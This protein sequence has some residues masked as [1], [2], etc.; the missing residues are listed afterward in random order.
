MTKF[1]LKLSGLAFV[2]ALLIATGCNT[3]DP[4]IDN[5]LGP[6][7]SL[8]SGDLELLEGE[9]FSVSITVAP[10]DN[11]LSSLRL[12]VGG[13]SVPA[14][15]ISD[16]VTKITSGG[17]DIL[18]QN[19]LGIDASRENG[20]TY[21]YEMVPFGQLEGETVSYSFEVTDKAQE[22]ASVSFD[23]TIVAPPGTP[24]EKEISGALLNQAGPAGTGGLD[25]DAGTGTGSNAAE[26]EIQ[27]EGID[28]NLS[29][30]NNWRRQIS[31][32][33]ANG[34]SL[35]TPDLTKLP[36]NFSFENI[37]IKEQ[38]KE[39]YDTGLALAGSDAACNCSDDVSG[40]EVSEPVEVG[41]MFVVKK[42]DVYYIIVATA[43]NV[44][45]GNNNDSYQ[46]DIKY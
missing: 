31:A 8:G 23:I 36:E 2:L 45:D 10:G 40:E 24:I 38:I 21:V 16:Y 39:A 9:A 13:A 25:L 37:T 44:T 20:A 29:T 14:A 11:P 28:L 4:I 42:G 3:D 17:E 5:P 26:A 46:F 32:V 27:D 1:F 7:I 15:S 22:K 30:A 35:R 43:V 18:Q 41:D 19:P 6:E 12:L 33:D 34:V